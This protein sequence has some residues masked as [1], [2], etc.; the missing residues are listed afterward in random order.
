MVFVGKKVKEKIDG[1]SAQDVAK[2]RS[3]IRK[4]WSWSWPKKLCTNRAVGKDGFSRC[5]LCKKKTPKV[6]IDHITPVGEVDG[7][8]ISRLFCPSSGLQAL[9]KKCHQTKTNAE[10]RERRLQERLAKQCDFY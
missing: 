9:C 5:E 7:G 8:F 2:I 10:N 1:L 4:V 3:A 6:F